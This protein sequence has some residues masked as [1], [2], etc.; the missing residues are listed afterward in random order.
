MKRIFKG[1][2]E[3]VFDRCKSTMNQLLGISSSKTVVSDAPTIAAPD[4]DLIIEE[5][6]ALVAAIIDHFIPILY[7]SHRYCESPNDAIGSMFQLI[8]HQ[9][10]AAEYPDYTLDYSQIRISP[11]REK[12]FFRTKIN[13]LADGSLVLSWIGFPYKR[14]LTKSASSTMNVLLVN[15]T[16]NISY[17]AQDIPYPEGELGFRLIVPGYT[18]GDEIICWMFLDCEERGEV[19]ASTY[20]CLEE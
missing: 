12:V 15:T 17:T 13:A 8:F 14:C 3:L 9:L 1:Y 5:K 6:G 11:G 16:K 20:C 18:I 19:S 7:K 10:S 2:G 4:S